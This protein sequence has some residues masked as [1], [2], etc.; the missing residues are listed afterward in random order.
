MKTF[1]FFYVDNM[2]DLITNSSSEL[3]VLK[4]DQP[5][6]MIERLV[7]SVMDV[8]YSFTVTHMSGDPDPRDEEWRMENVLKE[9][10]E[11]KRDEIKEKY[12]S[13]PK[14]YCVIVDRDAGYHT[15]YK[16]HNE[17]QKLGFHLETSDY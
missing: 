11:D 1:A 8:G 5:Q 15:D 10:P 3:F 6:D 16:H 14:W 4:A 17:L 12:F 2:I 7:L 13:D 9:F